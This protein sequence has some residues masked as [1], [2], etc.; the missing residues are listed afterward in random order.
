MIE[1]SYNGKGW[2]KGVLTL[3]TEETSISKIVGVLLKTLI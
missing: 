2:M 3:K 1:T